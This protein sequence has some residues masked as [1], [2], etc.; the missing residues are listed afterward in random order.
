MKLITSWQ[1]PLDQIIE[2]YLI[3]F[4]EGGKQ[5]ACIGLRCTPKGNNNVIATTADWGIVVFSEK[6]VEL[7]CAG[8]I[9][10]GAVTSA[11]SMV[12]DDDVLPT[13]SSLVPYELQSSTSRGVVLPSPLFLPNK[14]PSS[15]ETA[16]G[17]P[18]YLPNETLSSVETAYGTSLYLPNETPSSN[19]LWNS[20][21]SWNC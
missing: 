20:I 9:K 4:L 10:A 11:R 14:T 2:K 8:G 21:I 7:E 13:L 19:Y 6:K 3:K 18:L 5:V 1:N 15:V 16:Y 12:D 17:T